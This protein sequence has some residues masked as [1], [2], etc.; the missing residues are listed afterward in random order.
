MSETVVTN[1]GCSLDSN[2]LNCM[3]DVRL[4][5]L[6]NITSGCLFLPVIDGYQLKGF[7]NEAIGTDDFS[8]VPLLIGAN[9]DE[10]SLTVYSIFGNNITE[11]QYPTD[12]AIS[13]ALFQVPVTTVP[14]LTKL[15]PTSN[16]D[17][18]YWALSA[19]YSDWN[20]KCSSRRF[21]RLLSD[22]YPTQ[23][24]YL[25]EFAYRPPNNAFYNISA[26]L[27]SY[28]GAEIP[29]VWHADWDFPEDAVPLSIAVQ[30]YW[31]SFAKTQNPNYGGSVKWPT[32]LKSTDLN[33]FLNLTTIYTE[34]GMGVA[35]ECVFWDSYDYIPAARCI[36]GP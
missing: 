20:L 31:A 15:Y 32:Y 24:Y 33:I 7:P 28:H 4:E 22:A 5:T 16:Y 29:F 26:D 18:P 34:I 9:H 3:R 36:Y 8:N 25:Y 13:T 10:G 1:S 21:L 30:S 35:E 14:R 6:L 11:D 19:M 27:G 23:S 12:V 2:V 17:S